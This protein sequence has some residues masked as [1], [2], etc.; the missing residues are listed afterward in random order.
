MLAR[1]DHGAVAGALLARA[2][3]PE[4]GR[5]VVLHARLRLVDQA[6]PA[7]EEPEGG[8][9][10][11]PGRIGK[12]LVERLFEQELARQREVRGVEEVERDVPGVA[13]SGR[14][15]TAAPAR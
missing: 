2:E 9:D 3:T 1:E 12:A 5:M 14:S 6:Q 7:P 8:L 15:R 13:G 11:L 10:V 4:I